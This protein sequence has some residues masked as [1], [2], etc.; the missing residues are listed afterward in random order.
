M[1]RIFEFE[2]RVIPLDT[3]IQDGVD[4]LV[5]NYREWFQ[6]LKIPVERTLEGLEWMLGALSPSLVILAFALL[7]WRYA[8]RMVCVFSTLTLLL[9]GFLGLW[10]EAMTT[11]AM[12]ICSVVFC[13]LAGIPLGIA[14][15]RS[16]R[17]Q[18][19]LRPFLDAMQT[20]PA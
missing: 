19:L 4:W 14:S 6:V 11:L 1:T 12:V 17:F 8:S 18:M 16:D 15:G 3:W 10:E 2:E 13:A 7:A 20:T 5:F 9:I